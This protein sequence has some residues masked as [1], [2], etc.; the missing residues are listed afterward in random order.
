LCLR[1]LKFGLATMAQKGHARSRKNVLL[2]YFST[3][4]PGSV[5]NTGTPCAELWLES[6][7]DCDDPFE[8]IAVIHELRQLHSAVCDIFKEVSNKRPD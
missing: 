6:R 8:I 3:P 2:T 7:N 1:R 5:K 4:T